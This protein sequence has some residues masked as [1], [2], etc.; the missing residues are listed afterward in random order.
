MYGLNKFPL[1]IRTNVF[2]CKGKIES[3]SLFLCWANRIKILD[4]A[5]T[6]YASDAVTELG[7]VLCGCDCILQELYWLQAFCLQTCRG[8]EKHKSSDHLQ[9]HSRPLN[10][11]SDLLPKINKISISCLF[12][13]SEIFKKT[14]FTVTEQTHILAGNVYHRTCLRA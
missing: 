12:E 4:D 6:I 1:T 8:R 9:P 14:S 2:P 11:G 7:S 10:H 3:N 13:I 5:I